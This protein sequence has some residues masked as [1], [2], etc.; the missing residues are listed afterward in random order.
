MKVTTDNIAVLDLET[1]PFKYQRKPEPFAGGF[2]SNNKYI[3]TWGDNCVQELY[4]EIQRLDSAHVIYAHN[5]G[6]FDFFY[7][8]ELGL[9]DELKIVNGRILQAKCGKHEL[10]D[11]MGVFPMAL[12]AY[13]KDDIDYLWFERDVRESHKADI[14]HYLATDCEYLHELMTKFVDRFGDKL[15]I[16]GTA[17]AEVKKSHKFKQTN[18]A[19][20]ERFRP[21]YYGGRTEAFEV[22]TIKGDL[23]YFDV[24][25]MYPHVMASYKHPTGTRYNYHVEYGKQFLNDGIM[26]NPYFISFVGKNNGAL[27]TRILSG[28]K[29]GGLTFNAEHGEFFTTSHELQV[30]LKYG[31]V[32]IEKINYIYESLETINFAEFVNKFSQEKIDSKRANDTFTYLFVKF[33]LN[34]AYGKFGQNPENFFDYMIRWRDEK[35]PPEPWKPYIDGGFYE[36]WKKPNPKP[37][38]NDVATAA[39]ITGAARSVLLEAIVNSTR[40]LYCDTDSLICES[41]EN[42]VIDP[43][44]LGAWDIED[45]GDEICIAGKKLYA[46]FKDGECN[47]LASKGVRLTPEEIRTVCGGTDVKYRKESPSFK[48]HGGAQFIKRTVAGIHYN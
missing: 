2:L 21:F 32:E 15:T 47:K 8:L 20:D 9:I 46:M 23:K 26:E 31:R 35:L 45:E 34:S 37:I 7:F 12:A 16:G 14:L 1:D 30:A 24:N 40:P 22:G 38:Y 36:I 4:D 48:L 29:K 42:I 25:S 10:R 13:Q 28:P 6:K 43:T 33:I 19:H 17:I 39:S 5:G 18:K 27:P 3:E 44:R 41:I 11:S